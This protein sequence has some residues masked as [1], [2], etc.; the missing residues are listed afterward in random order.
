MEM[1][2]FKNHP[3]LK[4]LSDY[5][6]TWVNPSQD[7]TLNLTSA[8]SDLEADRLEVGWSGPSIHKTGLENR[9]ITANLV[10]SRFLKQT[11]GILKGFVSFMMNAKLTF[12][13]PQNPPIFRAARRFDNW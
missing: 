5:Y 13:A 12:F 6:H 2:Q 11:K 4:A 9:F 8:V 7:M 3:T 10:F 1:E